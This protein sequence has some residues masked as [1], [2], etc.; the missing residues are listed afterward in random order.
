M[1]VEGLL[2]PFHIEGQAVGTVWVVTHDQT[3][4]FDRED[5]R[6]LESFA[7]FAAAAYQ[8]R[9]AN[10]HLQT[11]IAERERAVKALSE[12]DRCK[13]E[14]LAQLGHELR[15]PLAPLRSA[16]DI[17]RQVGGD[18]QKVKPITEMMQRQIGQ[19]V[20]LVDDLLDVHRIS[21][22]KI[23]LRKEL[24]DLAS[25]VQHALEASRPAIEQA[26]H[27]LVVNVP[28]TPLYLDGDAARLVEVVA[29][30]LDND[31][32]FTAQGGRI[33]LTL[34]REGGDAV[35]RV[36]DTGIGI[37]SDMLLPIFDRFIQV[38]SAGK[39]AQGGLGLG[40]TLVKSLVELHGGTV[41]ACSSGVG[42]GSEFTVRLPLSA[43]TPRQSAVPA[44]G[45][46]KG[47]APR[48]IL[49]VDDNRD[50]AES[51]GVLLKLAGHQVFTAF[52]GGDA[53]ESAASLRPDVALLDIDLP[54]VSGYEAARQ[55]RAMPWGKHMVW[56]Q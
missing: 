20:R 22:G 7:R 40:L 2:A 24:V 18:E 39:H 10:T 8:I 54:V 30:L 17:L 35:I 3:R 44:D 36:R 46:R 1:L 41:K 28:A 26:K 4:K 37:A 12:A 11:E 31:C 45:E 33:R 25:V 27:K 51:L 23:A 38:D 19:I 42:Q 9:M 56:W 34:K 5:K 32:K 21:R 6:L 48:R 50:S 53:V 55:I 29:N 15:N 13:S 52:D 14:F 47:P 49:I 16:V 43:A